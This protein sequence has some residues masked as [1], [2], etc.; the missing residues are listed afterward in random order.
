MGT[1]GRDQ[2]GAGGPAEVAEAGT[3][4]FLFDLVPG[5][6]GAILVRLHAVLPHL[7]A[8]ES[9]WILDP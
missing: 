2:S 4:I 9:T 6:Q 3:D 1:P 5:E 8:P 7:G